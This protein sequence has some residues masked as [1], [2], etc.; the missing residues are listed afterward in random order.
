M[1]EKKKIEHDA[2]TLKKVLINKINNQISEI[3]QGKEKKF[4]NDNNNLFF[5]GFCDL[6]F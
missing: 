5:L 6:L 2:C 1:Q 4:F 3:I